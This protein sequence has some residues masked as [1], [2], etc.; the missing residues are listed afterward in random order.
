[1]RWGA[2]L[3]GGWLAWL[4][5]WDSGMSHDYLDVEDST[6]ENNIIKAYVVCICRRLPRAYTL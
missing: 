5:L 6:V 4:S 3:H 2:C 1:M